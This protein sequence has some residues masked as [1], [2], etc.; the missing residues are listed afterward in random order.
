MTDAAALHA[1]LQ[2]TLA[3]CREILALLEREHQAL[4]GPTQQAGSA[5]EFFRA[6]L[7]LVPRLDE[8]LGRLRQ[9]RAAWQR[10]TAQ[11]PQAAP[12][13][14]ALLRANQDLMLRILVLDRENQQLRLRHGLLTA[15]A[16]LA[17]ESSH[18]A[19][20]GFSALA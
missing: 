18:G 12:Q 3:L 8:A 6:R 17:S 14:A 2:A 20:H 11:E 4:T 9:H 5:F 15:G 10:L 13:L 1:A 19:R 16:R 7:H